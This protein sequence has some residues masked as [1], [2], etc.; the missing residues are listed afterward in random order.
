NMMFPG[1]MLLELDEAGGILSMRYCKGLVMTACL[2][3][4]DFYTPIYTH[5]VV[6][7]KAGLN[8]VGSS[9]LEV[10][11]KVLAEQPWS[12]EIRHALALRSGYNFNADELKFSAGAGLYANVGQT[13]G[14]V[15]YAY[16]DG[17]FLGAI[18]RL[19]L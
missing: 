16:T 9:S 19:S 13:H 3:A 10:G 1:K 11:V 6:T 18:N 4:M 12:G 15:D 14:S 5:E 7:F 17:G 8:H 2:D